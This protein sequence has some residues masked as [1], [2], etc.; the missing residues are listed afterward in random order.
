MHAAN[1]HWSIFVIVS[2]RII[3]CNHFENDPSSIAVTEEEIVTLIN[4]IQLLNAAYSIDWTDDEKKMF[5]NEL[6]SLN[7]F[8][9][10]YITA[11]SNLTDVMSLF[12]RNV[13]SDVAMPDI[14]NLLL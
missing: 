1:A 2:G 7:D 9:P 5:E 4:P 8:C 10:I 14:K 3:S 6:Q 12:L 13:S 11:E